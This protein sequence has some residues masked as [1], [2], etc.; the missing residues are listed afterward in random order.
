MRGVFEMKL[1]VVEARVADLIWERAPL[2]SRQLVELCEV[3][4]QWKRT[5][6]YTMLKRLCEKGIFQHENKMITILVSKETFYSKQGEEVV[7][8][9]FRG[10]LPAFLTAFASHKELSEEE[11]DELQQVIERLK[12]KKK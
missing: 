10:S 4:F 5:T 6:T 2:T 9:A 3:E 11:L 12:R 8:R 7:E 1:S